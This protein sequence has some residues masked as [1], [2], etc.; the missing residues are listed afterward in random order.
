MEG[1][2]QLL[3]LFTEKTGGSRPK[4]AHVREITLLGSL[5]YHSAMSLPFWSLHACKY[6]FIYLQLLDTDPSQISS[7]TKL[8][9]AYF[10]YY[11]RSVRL[12][13]PPNVHGEMMTATL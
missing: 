10:A 8:S 13:S 1:S 4:F 6:T 9:I 12:E 7:F 5:G 2:F 11:S 3:L